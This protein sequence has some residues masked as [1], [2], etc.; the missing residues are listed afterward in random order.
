MSKVVNG[1]IILD[2]EE[3]KEF[4]KDIFHPDVEALKK[5]THSSKALKIG[6][7]NA[8]E[9]VA[10]LS[11]FLIQ[12]CHQYQKQIYRIILLLNILSRFLLML[13][14]IFQLAIFFHSII[15]CSKIENSPIESILI[16]MPKSEYPAP[17]QIQI[18][19][20]FSNLTMIFIAFNPVGLQYIPTILLVCTSVASDMTFQQ[21]GLLYHNKE[22]L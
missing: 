21:L 19:R 7:F 17:L 6:S 20:Q 8:Q 13:L 12:N 9:M 14:P 2:K 15:N 3:S 22:N 18:F 11:I 10:L 1:R 5:G 4:L 16:L